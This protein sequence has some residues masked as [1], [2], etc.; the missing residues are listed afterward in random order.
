[1][2]LVKKASLNPKTSKKFSRK[3]HSRVSIAFVMSILR[4][5][6]LPYDLLWSKLVALEAMK[7]H[8]SDYRSS[9]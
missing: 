9:G 6:F 4:S 7:R 5:K 8:N 1:M 3:D 2:N